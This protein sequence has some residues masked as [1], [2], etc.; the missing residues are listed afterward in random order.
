V[1]WYKFCNTFF[2][3]YSFVIK[4]SPSDRKA[5]KCLSCCFCKEWV[6]L[7]SSLYLSQYITL[8]LVNGRYFIKCWFNWCNI[9]FGYDEAKISSTISEVRWNITRILPLWQWDTPL[10]IHSFITPSFIQQMFA[11]YLRYDLLSQHVKDKTLKQWT[12]QKHLL[13]S[14]SLEKSLRKDWHWADDHE[15][16]KWEI[17]GTVYIKGKFNLLRWRLFGTIEGF[18]KELAFQVRF[19]EGGGVRYAKAGLQGCNSRQ[20]ERHQRERV[21]QVFKPKKK[22]VWLSTGI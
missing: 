8:C 14:G 12:R 15:Y 9:F 13:T 19:W 4:S 2:P 22:Q 10:F 11:E 17:Q 6:L 18:P 7:Y 20:R 21:R 16:H 3:V 5:P 1:Y